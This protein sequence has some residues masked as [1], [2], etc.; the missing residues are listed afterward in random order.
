MIKI[1]NTEVCGFEAAVRGMVGKGYRERN[2]VYEAFT[3]D[4]SNNKKYITCHS[5]KE[6]IEQVFNFRIKRFLMGI[7]E[8][9]LNEKD[10]KITH[11]KYVVFKTGEIF[12]LYGK[13]IRGSIDRGGYIEVILNNKLYRAHRVVA[14]AFIPNIYN[15]PCVNHIDGNK[16]NNNINNLEWVTY[17]QNTLHA[18]QIGLERKVAGEA[19]HAHKLTEESVKYIKKVYKKRDKNYGAASLSGKFNVHSSTILNVINGKTWRSCL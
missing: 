19:H 12:N 2:G 4:E 5:K 17:S 1:E 10:C 13:Q 16:L 6:V 3:L 15:C 7:H 11:E 8:N 14:E 18:Y 9:G